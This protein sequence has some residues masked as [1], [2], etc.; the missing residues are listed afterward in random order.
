MELEAYASTVT[1]EDVLAAEAGPLFT[2]ESA[3]EGFC[4]LGVV[5]F[6]P[7]EDLADIGLK[8]SSLLDE[9]EQVRAAET[10][11]AIE[12]DLKDPI[13]D[14]GQGLRIDLFHT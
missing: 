11:L 3:E 1:L 14:L 2:A 12:V 6:E 4:E 9:F 7:P 10:D 5:L 13:R 8:I